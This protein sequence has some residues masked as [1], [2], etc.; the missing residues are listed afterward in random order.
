VLA[1][2]WW[3]LP[4]RRIHRELVDAREELCDADALKGATNPSRVAYARVLLQTLRHASAPTGIV[5]SGIGG[6][7]DGV[8][9]RMERIVGSEDTGNMGLSLR[10]VT[11]SL[12]L[13]ASLTIALAS[14][15]V[16]Q[17]LADVAGING[18]VLRFTPAPDGHEATYRVTVVAG[19]QRIDG[20]QRVTM[21]RTSADSWTVS[22]ARVDT[23][24]N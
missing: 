18:T 21:R 8:R 13:L 5:V 17:T 14:G 23:Q 22:M 10:L 24:K 16:C 15:T 20:L 3:C 9:R 11:A 2:L 6:T 19:A 1:L 7:F 4:L 12:I